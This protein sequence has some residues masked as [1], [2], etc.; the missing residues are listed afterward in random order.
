MVGHKRDLIL[1]LVT[2][3]VIQS[4]TVAVMLVSLNHDPHLS[5]T[6]NPTLT[7]EVAD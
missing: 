3:V 4:R 1:T 6:S 7:T 5:L 2:V